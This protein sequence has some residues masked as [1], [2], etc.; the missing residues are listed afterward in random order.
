MKLPTSFWQPLTAGAEVAALLSPARGQVDTPIRSEI[1]GAARFA[2]HGRS[3]GQAH[4]A[5]A[6]VR[7]APFFPRL[8]ENIRVLREAHS[9]MALQEGTGHG[10]GPAGEWLLD[11]FYVVMAQVKEIYEGLPRRYFRDLPVLQEAHLAG[12][13]RIYGVAWAFVAHTDSAFDEGLLEGFLHAYQSTRELTLGELWAL[14]TTLRVVLVENLRRLSERVATT[15]AAHASANAWFEGWKA[16]SGTAL[17]TLV[18]LL[19]DLRVRGVERVFVLQ[20]LQRLRSDMASTVPGEALEAVQKILGQALPDPAAAQIQQHAEQTADNLS[21][22]NAIVSLRLLGDTDWRGLVARTSLLV[23]KLQPSATF[24]AERDDTRD[25][26]LHAIERLARRSARSELEVAGALLQL[27]QV[28]AQARADDVCSPEAARHAQ[29]APGYWL[30]GPGLP[31]LLRALGLPGRLVPWQARLQRAV[32]PAYLGVIGAATAAVAAAFAAHA[33][34]HASTPWMVCI[35]L[36]ALWP[37]S[38]AVI[39]VLHRLISESLPPQRL[40]RLAFADGIPPAHRVLVVIPAM[41]SDLRGIQALVR[42]LELHYLANGES[43]AQFALLSDFADAPAQHLEGDRALLDAAVAALDALELRHAQAAPPPQGR[44]FLLLHRQRVWSQSEQCWMGWERKRGKL[45]QLV[46]LLAATAQGPASSPAVPAPFVD[47]GACSRP[48]GGTPYIV[49]LDSDTG[50]P[51]GTLRALVGVAAHPLNHPCIDTER[52]RVVSGYGI[53]QPRLTTPLPDPESATPFHWLFGGQT[54]IDPYSAAASEIY[55]DVFAEGSFTGKG[56]LHVAALHAVLSHRMPE[57]LILSH[58]LL[59]GSIA[60]CA[61][62]TD[63]TLIEE[64]PMH[65]D[66]AASRVHRWTRG[67]WQLWPVLVQWQRFD[68]RAIHRWKMLDNLRRSLVAP[69]SVALL[70]VCMASG[71]A[72]PWAALALVAAAL[73]AGPLLGAVAGLAPARDDLALAYFYRRAGAEVVRAAGGTLWGLLQLLQQ[74]LLLLDAIGTA[75]WRLLVSRRGLL[76][77]TTAAS[78]QAAVRHSLA[79]LVLQHWAIA[80]AALV[81]AAALWWGGAHWPVTGAVLCALWAASPLWTWWGSR[82]WRGAGPAPASTRERE[83]LYGVAQDTWQFFARYVGPQ[84]MHLPPDNVQFTPQVMVAHRTSPTNMG[85]Y[86]LSAACA[87]RLGWIDTEEFLGRCEQTLATMGRLQRH[88]GHFLNW[89][90]T[91]TLQPLAPEYVSTVDSGN[92][93]GHLEALAGAC[94]E[95]LQSTAAAPGDAAQH[96][97]QRLRHLIA[98]CHA[99][100]MEA[101]FR[102]LYDPQRGLFHIG[103]N[104]QESQLDKSF[105]D[106]LAS[107]ARLASVWGIAKGDIPVSH[108]SALGRPFYAWSTHLGLRSWSGSMF[109]YLMP[110]LVLEEPAG[111]VLECAARMA[112]REQQAF[113]RKRGVPWGISE[114]AYAATDATLAYQ[115][116]PQGVPRLALR[117]TPPDELVVAPYATAMAAMFEPAQAVANLRW[118]ER[119]HARGDMGFIE[120][121]DFTAERQMEGSAYVRVQTCMSHHQGMALVALTNVLLD[122]VPRRWATRLGRLAA[123][124]SL[125]HERA[126]REV[127]RLQAPERV[128]KLPVRSSSA[129]S[130]VQDVVP[131]DSALQPTLLLSNGRYSVAVRPNGAGWSRFQGADVSRWRDDALRDTHG[132]FVYVRRHGP[133]GLGAPVS[134][135]QHPAPDP[136]AR[137]QATL[138]ID[139]IHLHAQWRDLRSCCKVWVSPEDDIELRNVQ[140]WNRTDQPLE[141][142]LLSM[143]EVSLLEARADEAHPAFANLFVH[144]DWDSTDQALYFVRKPHIDRQ[145]PLHAVHFVA[146]AEHAQVQVQA[147][148]DRA[149]WLG[150]NREASHPLAHCS[151]APADAAQDRASAERATGLD[152]VAALSVRITVPAHGSV[153]VTLATAVATSRDTLEMLVDRYRQPTAIER[154]LL[155]STTFASVRMRD[156]GLTLEERHAIQHVT[157]LMALLHAR[158]PVVGAGAGAGGPPLCDHRTLWRFGMSGERPLVVVDIASL[159]G[160]PLVRTLVQ[161][162]RLWSWGGIVCDL[163]VLNAEPRSYLMPLQLELQALHERHEAEA[164]SDPARA[165]GLKVLFA[166]DVTPPEQQALR[167]L[168]RLYLHADG[169]SLVR[170]VRDLVQWHDAALGPRTDRALATPPVPVAHAVTSSA[171]QGRFDADSGDYAFGVGPQHRPQRPWI[172]VLANER[173]GAHIS[174]AGAGYTWAGNSRLHQLTTW[175]NDPVADS[176]GEWFWVQDQ[177][178]REVWNVGAGAGAA[179]ASAVYDVVHGQGVTTIRHRRGDLEVSATWCVDAQQPLKHVRISVRNHGTRAVALRVLGAMEWVM[180][181]QR[182]ARQSVHTACVPV[183]APGAGALAAEVLLATQCDG[184]AG[185]GGATAFLA[186][187][188]EGAS[189]ARLSDWTC[190]RR[191]LF[192]SR[193]QR[194]LPTRL[195]ARAGLGLDPCA[196]AST[197]LQLAPGAQQQCVFVIGHG[198]TPSAATDLAA[199]GFAQPAAERERAVQAHWQGLLGA[200]TVRTPDALFDALTNHWLL[201]QTVACRL[202]ARAGFY[203]AGGAFG[204]RDQLQDTMAL[205]VSAPQLLRQQLLLAASRQFVEGDV[206]HWWHMPTGAGVRTRCSDDLLWLPSAVARYVA[207]T[208]DAAVL[209]EEVPFLDGPPIP[210]DAADI[211][212]VP[213]ISAQTA[214]L[215][216]HCVRAIERSL[217]VGAHGLPLIGAGDWND[218]MSHVGDQGRG[219]SVWLAMFLYQLVQDFAPLALER[220]DGV[221]AQRWQQAAGSWQAAVQAHAWDGEWFKRA[222]FDDG[223][224]LGTHSAQECRIDLIAQAWSVL[225]G[226]APEVQQRT[227]MASAAQWLVDGAHGLNRLLTPPLQNAVPRAGYIQAY[228]PGV[229]ENGGQYS[230]AGVWKLMA[231]IGLNDADGAYRTFTQLSPAHRSADPLQGP[232]YA[233]EPYV[234]VADVYTHAPYV[235]RG[236]WS[237]YTGSAAWMHRAAV[238][239][240]CGLQV[241]AQRVRLCP[242]LPSHWPSIAVHWQRQ[243]GSALE[244]IVCRANAAGLADA[245]A[246]ATRELAVG[247]WLDTADMVDRADGGPQPQCILV[248]LP[249]GPEPASPPLLPAPHAPGV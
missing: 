2:Q 25:A 197:L 215:Y 69:L 72:S 73:G 132:T 52:R 219:E 199:H 60:R 106:L 168:A 95:L 247:E 163:V 116:A 180:G 182:L 192:D 233:V 85:L 190:D 22:R 189:D 125:L 149:A 40:P 10:V 243:D 64:A 76:R 213:E 94:D 229:R 123:V 184:H 7:A 46:E 223:T 5:R 225:S 44:R 70:L 33:A 6:N 98:Q 187:W 4:Q 66:V 178:T 83:Y 28:P 164:L 102:F 181:A 77:W 121:L 89:Y 172:N 161:A 160:M 218:G 35:A 43:E 216:E 75:L 232:L 167:L 18:S 127:S 21:V 242:Q 13:P 188:R 206:Q 224:P 112:V 84:S 151:P 110:S 8:R 39:A 49:T 100:A 115:Y 34:H 19:E 201:Y 63:I 42:Q 140:L 175:T 210:D 143:W 23:R 228:P 51:P 173:F 87:R 222:F 36:L 74:A 56:L 205:A 141:L 126:P 217:V 103:Y 170:H 37:A 130:A 119:L 137:Y 144:A 165:G 226:I 57:G 246:R 249:A 240:I 11:N 133:G 198:A 193:G 207:I 214:S 92:L 12:L 90:D 91:Q 134:L 227:A 231:Q 153:Q 195:G 3:L 177:R 86:L 45:E 230:H 162:L 54:G 176:G 117:R 236:G 62:V 118:L 93:C 24:C 99:L 26:N 221:R 109:E 211:Y 237:W 65:A 27:M 202:W 147:Q 169:R 59:E 154:S 155:M 71:A 113:A 97:H 41:L 120:S 20:V 212:A 16:D 53:L 191:E 82:P 159:N 142:D 14:P 171:P 158:P 179:S 157:S 220:Q 15:K 239:S 200:V 50:L 235:G 32:T 88:Q 48:A 238:E 105:Y 146:H 208:G 108:W 96:Q 204:Y 67:D 79:R 68:L 80:L 128:R 58:D 194:A 124:E 196:A 150:R 136:Q 107:E 61:A 9:Y 31:A 209:D 104:L 166:G 81:L 47:L 203:Q 30:H 174:E 131:G 135:T 122:G 241:R 234:M 38:E 29:A 186:L 148:T 78:A 111:S 129:T 156:Q 244:F 185:F 139:H 152:P 101:D 17:Q 114:S 183:Q 245:Q 55:Q 145:A 1:F 138:H 248:R